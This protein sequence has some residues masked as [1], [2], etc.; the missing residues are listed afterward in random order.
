[1][2]H[3]DGANRFP[4]LALCAKTGTAERGDGT[5]NAWFAGFLLD[6]AHPYAFVVLIEQGGGGLQAAGGA[7]NEILQYAVGR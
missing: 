7:A 6:E 5:S 3:Y 4:G 2:H 1:M